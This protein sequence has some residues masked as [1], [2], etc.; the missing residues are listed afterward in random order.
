MYCRIYKLTLVF[1]F[2][3]S[4]LSAQNGNAGLLS[5]N[6][7]SENKLENPKNLD[8]FLSSLN[9]DQEKLL[10]LLFISEGYLYQNQYKNAVKYIFQAENLAQKTTSE[11]LK[12]YTYILLSRFY[13]G[14][15]L[16]KKAEESL[17]KAT[18]FLSLIKDESREK[19]FVE[20]K[21]QLEK[22]LL[23]LVSGKEKS[24]LQSLRIS[25]NVFESIQNEGV[26]LMPLSFVYSKI[27]NYYLSKNQLDSAKIYIDKN[28]KLAENPLAVAE[29]RLLANNNMSQFYLQK[30]QSDSA[31]YFAE[32]EVPLLSVSKNDRLKKEAYKNLA[33][34]YYSLHN[35]EKYKLYNQ[36]FLGLND[37]IY[38]LDRETRVILAN[39]A[40]IETPENQSSNMMKWIVVALG[41]SVVVLIVIYAYHL[42]VKKEY[43]HFQKIM[44]SIDEKEDFRITE[45]Q[46]VEEVVVQHQYSISEKTEQ[47]LLEKLKRFEESEKYINPKVSLQFLAKHL[48][49]NTKYL[50][51]I[52]NTTKGQN[53]NN[54]INDLRIKYILKKLKSEI[55]YQNYKV[56][57]LAEECG[58][59][60]RNTFTLAFKNSVGMSPAKFIGFMKKENQ[61]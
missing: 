22:G 42:K 61:T 20:A 58:F 28:L 12:S 36:K 27:G 31:L 13:R 35:T 43:A 32:K 46:P 21:Y 47:L 44:K 5:H 34:I 45:V 56:E 9:S 17:E 37:S 49:T 10:N 53:F 51:E 11:N 8:E 14:V 60:S 23:N 54:Y 16:N 24:A 40:E 2:F 25:Q 48:D 38:E 55:K 57:S 6:D 50:S 3:I 29:T 19:K 41:F 7:F 4:Y 52:I 1:V 59:N 33:Q 15:E 18:A 30:K 39:R 26:V